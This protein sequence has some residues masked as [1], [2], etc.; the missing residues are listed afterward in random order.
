MMRRRLHEIRVK[1]NLRAHLVTVT[2]R[3]HTLLIWQSA[4]L[5][6]I[7]AICSG[8]LCQL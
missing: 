1:R 2:T 8:R 7:H 4:R 3:D 5:S 6:C